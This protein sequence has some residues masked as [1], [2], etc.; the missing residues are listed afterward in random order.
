MS[1]PEVEAIGPAARCLRCDGALFL[2]EPT[3]PTTDTEVS[4][5]VPNRLEDDP[6]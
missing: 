1:D 4:P 6:T 5:P 3:G 2:D